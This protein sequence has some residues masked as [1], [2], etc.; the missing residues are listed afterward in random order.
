MQKILLIEDD[1]KIS[2]H[3]KESLSLSGYFVESFFKLED[4]VA[5][6]EAVSNFDI[7]ILDRLFNGQDSKTLIPFFKHKCQNCSILIISAINTPDEKSSL[8][9]LGAD[10][11][12]GKPF[13]T[14]E[15]ISR[16][17]ALLRRNQT[18]TPSFNV[19]GKTT[20]RF[21]YISKLVSRCWEYSQTRS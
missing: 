18:S 21:F 4:A 6:V 17:K 2:E 5:H 7:I 20:T 12:L 1:L 14:M 13:S 16:I 11:Y 9:D 19:I 3:L 8:L 15:L 10:D